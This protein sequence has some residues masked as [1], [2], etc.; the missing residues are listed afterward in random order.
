MKNHINKYF[1]KYLLLLLITTFIEFIISF[2]EFHF[3]SAPMN[4]KELGIIFLGFNILAVFIIAQIHIF[5]FGFEAFTYMSILMS[6]GL[7]YEFI[8][9]SDFALLKFCILF[10]GL[11]ILFRIFIWPYYLESKIYNNPTRKI[12]IDFSVLEDSEEIFYRRI[13]LQANNKASDLLN[14][15]KKNYLV[16][17]KNSYNKSYK[18]YIADKLMYNIDES[19]NVEYCQNIDFELGNFPMKKTLH[20]KVEIINLSE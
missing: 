19:G 14:F 11:S 16:E 9:T 15:F 18:F 8:K 7:A 12:K 5:G 13:T 4:F 10:S 1:T 17:I 20:S 3:Q 2:F 6:I